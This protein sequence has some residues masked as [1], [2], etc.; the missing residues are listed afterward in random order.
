MKLSSFAI[1]AMAGLAL[2]QDDWSSSSSSSSSPASSSSSP[3]PSKSSN[4]S[5][6]VATP[7]GVSEKFSNSTDL[8]TNATSSISGSP[9]GTG[10]VTLPSPTAGDAGPAIPT[11]SLA[12]ITIPSTATNSCSTFLSALNTDSNLQTCLG[13]TLQVLESNSASIETFCNVT[14]TQGCP[15]GTIKRYLAN[16]AGNC[17]KELASSDKNIVPLFDALYLLTPLSM[18][19]CAKDA[20]GNFCVGG[21]AK[22]SNATTTNGGTANVAQQPLGVNGLPNPD[23]FTSSNVPF[24]GAN[25]DLDEQDLCTTCTRNALTSYFAFEATFPY[26]NGLATSQL[27]GSQNALYSAIESKCPADFLSSALSN[28]GAAPDTVNGAIS[29]T[30]A[31]GL[32]SLAAVAVGFLCL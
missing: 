19:A 2:A 23:A 8:S 16:F 6:P 15:S 18:A 29:F 32:I 24:L 4:S 25:P 28:A 21:S 9:S 17:S 11:G 13:P 22:N 30:P 7:T 27:L 20:N 14:A 3:G 12:N 10:N 26:P 31:K 1:L 5:I